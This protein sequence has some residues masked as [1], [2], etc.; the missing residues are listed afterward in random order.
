MA[1]RKATKAELAKPVNAANRKSGVTQSGLP[2]A[3]RIAKPAKAERKTANTVG[4]VDLLGDDSYGTYRLNQSKKMTKKELEAPTLPKEARA[5]QLAGSGPGRSSGLSDDVQTKGTLSSVASAIAKSGAKLTEPKRVEVGFTDTGIPVLDPKK[6]IT[7]KQQAERKSAAKVSQGRQRKSVIEGV[8]SGRIATDLRSAEARQRFFTDDEDQSQEAK[9][10]AAVTGGKVPVKKAPIR[11]ANPRQGLGIV[12]RDK[13]GKLVQGAVS[14]ANRLGPVRR[15][16]KSVDKDTTRNRKEAEAALKA[17]EAIQ[18]IDETRQGPGSTGRGAPVEGMTKDA[19]YTTGTAPTPADVG[20]PYKITEVTGG[21]NAALGGKVEATTRIAQTAV[22]RDEVLST[23]NSEDKKSMGN[24]A[25]QVV[26]GAPSRTGGYIGGT[27]GSSEVTPEFRAKVAET[28]AADSKTAIPE[29]ITDLQGYSF[30]DLLSDQPDLYNEIRQSVANA[31]SRRTEVSTGQ[32]GNRTN[33][34]A[35]GVEDEA[36]ILEGR[37]WRERLNVHL[38]SLPNDSARKNLESRLLAAGAHPNSP[39]SEAEE[40]S[41]KINGTTVRDSSNEAFGKIASANK[42]VATEVASVSRRRRGSTRTAP[43]EAITEQ[44][45]KK[46]ART[47][48]INEATNRTIANDFMQPQSTGPSARALADRN[49]VTDPTTGQP[50]TG[51]GVMAAVG[52]IP[53]TG[54]GAAQPTS[55]QLSIM[56]D[57]QPRLAPVFDRR[58]GQPGAMSI[59]TASGD[60]GSIPVRANDGVKSED[61]P[62]GRGTATGESVAFPKAARMPGSISVQFQTPSGPSTRGVAPKAMSTASSI[63]AMSTRE[64][65]GRTPWNSLS[66]GTEVMVNDG[67]NGPTSMVRSSQFGNIQGS[68]GVPATPENM[69]R[70]AARP[71]R[72]AGISAAKKVEESTRYARLAEIAAPGV[73]ARNR[74]AKDLNDTREALTTGVNKQ[75]DTIGFMKDYDALP[76]GSTSGSKFKGSQGAMFS[77]KTGKYGEEDVLVR[78]P[79]S[80][81]GTSLEKTLTGRGIPML[82]GYSSDDADLGQAP[83][84]YKKNTNLSSGQ[85]S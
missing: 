33:T 29:D 42:A 32:G 53:L 73:K 78:D 59:T 41:T 4:G 61:N 58:P 17:G 14:R 74:E 13:S 83:S 54:S 21:A 3:G 66:P 57:T 5:T 55:D 47:L 2:R 35:G 62:F 50:V 65:S 40:K 67:S 18:G 85:F 75:Y 60:V 84:A 64:A 37:D 63:A 16:A 24:L 46:A 22:G 15:L 39:I 82:A 71:R 26:K 27:V 45:G 77:E 68:G 9:D 44:S 43:V 36:P 69:R 31:K 51:K 12:G 48:A 11:T 70:A 7:P 28:V 20:K 76:S 8:Q 23:M 1:S 25:Q 52:K 38:A 6:S 72:E 81:S 56:K 30:K 49:K 10:I 34:T 80:D 79:R 19:V